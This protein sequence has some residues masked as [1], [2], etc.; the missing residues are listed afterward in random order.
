MR[1]YMV[2]TA[3][4]KPV[5]LASLHWLC[6][7]QGM[8]CNESAE[9]ISTC[10]VRTRGSGEWFDQWPSTDSDEDYANEPWPDTDDDILYPKNYACAAPRE[11][12]ETAILA[13]LVA[14]ENHVQMPKGHKH[15]SSIEFRSLSE[16]MAAASASNSL[17][18]GKRPGLKF[19]KAFSSSFWLLVN[20]ARPPD[21]KVSHEK[22]P[23]MIHE[24]GFEIST[25]VNHPFPV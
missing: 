13:T 20:F 5:M 11:C 22:G 19:R 21:W 16:D 17:D 1:I 15:R 9:T 12:H 18:G 14:A 7:G 25:L 2:C 8:T 24:F 6:G 3:E 10:S 4:W 23:G